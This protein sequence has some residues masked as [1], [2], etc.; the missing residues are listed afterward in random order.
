M[1]RKLLNMT[2]LA[3]FA[4]SVRAQTGQTVPIYRVTVIE[5]TVKAVNYQYRNG[6]TPIDFRGTVLL[7]KAKGSAIV[8]SKAGRTEI[9]AHFDHLEA[10]A[11]YGGEYLTYV[12]WAITPEGHAKNLGEVLANG[13]DKAHLRVTTGLQAFGL[14]VTAEPYSAVREPSDV[15][16]MENEV[17]PDTVGKIE[18]VAAK[19][20]LLPRGHYEYHVPTNLKEAGLAGPSVSMDQYEQMV[21]VYQAQNALQIARAAGAERYAADTLGKAETLL[22]TAQ[23]DMAR[24][25]DK[26][27][28]VSNAREAAQMADDARAIALRHTQDGEAAAAREQVAHERELRMQAE[29]EAQ[30][31]K[32][33]SAADRQ[34]LEQ[35]RAA[36]SRAE[37]EAQEARLAP[38][39]PPPQTTTVSVL[40]PVQQVQPPPADTQK[41]EQR[42]RLFRE[43]SAAA[44]TR[45]TPRGLVVTIPDTEFHGSRLKDGA[46]GNLSTIALVIAR[47]PGLYVQV[48]GNTDNLGSQT[49]DEDVSYVRAAAVRDALMRAGVPSSELSARGLGSSR[50]LVSNATA[51]G[52]EQNRRVEITISGSPIGT[53]PYWDKT[54]SLR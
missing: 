36:R 29:A 18:Q 4:V 10:P 13:S 49:N 11:R 23:S 2:M 3:L 41:G 14:I 6:P 50:P 19:Y 5:R 20:E 32:A 15:V 25:M 37:A 46:Y 17:R 33:Q 51:S 35:E 21:E 1:K 47:H 12:L 44:T 54:Y 53:L 52:R 7:P 34:Q 22:H 16:V 48:E 40:Q 43:L 42:M 38:V 28:V 45:D 9:D 27:I 26:T 8:E 30:R 24:K 39:P 31:L